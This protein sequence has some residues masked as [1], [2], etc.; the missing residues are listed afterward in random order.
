MILGS[1]SLATLSAPLTTSVLGVMDLGVMDLHIF[2]PILSVGLES[3]DANA[4]FPKMI[5]APSAL[6]TCRS[7]A[8]TPG[9]QNYAT[10]VANALT[11]NHSIF[12]SAT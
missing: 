4:S 5:M 9:L 10:K 8:T 11:A 7:L 3:A 12:S 6:M 1:K 2:L